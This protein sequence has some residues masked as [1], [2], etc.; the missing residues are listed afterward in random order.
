MTGDG[1]YIFAANWCTYIRVQYIVHSSI[2]YGHKKEQSRNLPKMGSRKV[3]LKGRKVNSN[4]P[5]S[6]LNWLSPISKER[7][8]LLKWLSSVLKERFVFSNW[9]S[10][11]L[12]ERSKLC[13]DPVE[14]ARSF[15]FLPFCPCATGTPAY[16]VDEFCFFTDRGRMR[17]RFGV[18]LLFLLL[19][20]FES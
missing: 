9:L 10:T 3:N 16:P 8:F 18:S 1:C 20:F 15:P 11:D 2:A 4:L 13:F 19:L 5:F 6:L 14:Q 17:L 12:K 7:N